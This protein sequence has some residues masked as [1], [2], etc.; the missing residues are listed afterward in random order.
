MSAEVSHRPF[1]ERYFAALLAGLL[2]IYGAS[3]LLT[4]LT[5]VEAVSWHEELAV[6]AGARELLLGLKTSF[7]DFQLDGYS[8]ESLIAAPVAALFFKLLGMSLVSLKLSAVFVYLLTLLV[9]AF[10]MKKN[11]GARAALWSVFFLTFLPPII[12]AKTMVPV[13]GHSESLFFT[14]CMFYA[15]SSYLS[16]RQTAARMKRLVSFGLLA[17]F[18][19]WFYYESGI[20]VLACLITWAV[21][22]RKSFFSKDLL[23]TVFCFAAGFSPWIYAFLTQPENGVKFLSIVFP[24]RGFIDQLLIVPKRIWGMLLFSLPESFSFLPESNV[25]RRFTAFFY[26]GFCFISVPQFFLRESLKQAKKIASLK[27]EALLL[28]IVYPVLFLLVY[29][30]TEMDVPSVYSHTIIFRYYMPLYFVLFLSLGAAVCVIP[31]W[32]LILLVA[33]SIGAQK[34]LFFKEEFGRGLLLKGYSY[35]ELGTYWARYLTAAPDILK[36]LEDFPKRISE[37][38]SENLFRGMISEYWSGYPFWTAPGSKLSIPENFN[39]VGP[40]YRKI[41]IEEAASFLPVNYQKEGLRELLAKA[42]KL[43]VSQR[44]FFYKGILTDFYGFAVREFIQDPAVRA[45][46]PKQ[47]ADWGFFGAGNFFYSNP[48]S[49]EEL[50]TLE[51]TVSSFKPAE[52]SLYYRGLGSALFYDYLSRISVYEDRALRVRKVT[53]KIPRE[54]WPDFLWGTGHALRSL[55]PDDKVRA[56]KWLAGIP[57]LYRVFALQGLESRDSDLSG[58]VSS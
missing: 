55:W 54:S 49:G 56:E 48:Q 53:E 2:L 28:F 57:A 23:I 51:Q 10:F 30:L 17:G 4:L 15:F 29:G 46:V 45:L 27:P 37:D 26:F 5:A 31:R 42:E 6:G 58:K 24:V 50:Q 20:A 9:S 11:F 19:F 3:R 36:P 33:L 52:K 13:G 39:A 16:A 18:N 7:W 12:A 34:P 44:E 32:G 38:G 8:G 40:K 43:P 1:S 14:V 41:F 35:Y 47:Y 22:S 25:L 21:V